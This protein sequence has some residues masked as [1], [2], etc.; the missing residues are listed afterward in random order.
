MTK[1]HSLNIIFNN[2]MYIYIVVDEMKIDNYTKN[3]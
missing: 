3:N 2:Y 1:K